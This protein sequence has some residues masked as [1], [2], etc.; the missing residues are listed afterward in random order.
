[1]KSGTGQ[2]HDHTLL[3]LTRKDPRCRH[4]APYPFIHSN[5]GSVRTVPTNQE[6]IFVWFMTIRGKQILA[7]AIGIQKDIWG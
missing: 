4:F 3:S 2:R 5:I 1:M 7:M 6:H